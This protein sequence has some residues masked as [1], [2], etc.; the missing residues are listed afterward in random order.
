MPRQLIDNIERSASD[1]VNEFNSEG[2]C[3]GCGGA[4][5]IS[6]GCVQIR[7]FG[8]CALDIR[9]MLVKKKDETMPVFRAAP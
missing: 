7:H 1:F 3:P 8:V 6:A 4:A 5:F 9:R 2:G